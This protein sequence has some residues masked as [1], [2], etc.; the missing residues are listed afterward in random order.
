M[1]GF[2][3]ADPYQSPTFGQ[4]LSL[5]VDGGFNAVSINPSGRDVV[6]A[7]RTGLYVI[8]LDDPFS[9]PRWLQH[10]TSWQ[11]ADVQWSPHPAKPYWV[12]STSNQKAMV[13]NLARSSPNAI[14]HELHGHFRAITD[15]NFHPNHP[16]ILAT[17]SIDT[18]VHAWD[19]RS[20]QRPY[21]STRDLTAGASQ[22][23]WNFQDANILASS[24]SNSV[25]IWD[26]RKGCTPLHRLAA[27]G[28]SVNNIDFNRFTE[29]EIMSS[30]NNGT[31]KFWDYK[32]D[33]TDPQFTIQADFPIRRGRYLPF[34]EGCCIMPMVGGN[35]SVY[36][37]NN[38]WKKELIE[39]KKSK[40]QPIY[41]FKGHSNIVT[42]FLWRCRH[43]YDSYTD[44]RE[45]QLVTWSKDCNLRLWPVTSSTYEKVNFEP[46]KRLEKK[47]P[48]YEYVTF[49]N[50]PEKVK[51]TSINNYKVIPETFVTNSGFQ[52]VQQR[53]LNHLYW[54]SGVKMNQSSSPHD[55][56]SDS[57]LQSLGEE[58]SQV[59]HKFNK[60]V[61][62]K[63]SV[64]TGEL[65]LTLNGPWA[66][67]VTSEY[68]FLRVEIN[69]SKN[70]P[71]KG[72]P[73]TFKLEENTELTDERKNWL[74][75]QLGEISKIC[76]E[77]GKYCLE[78]C[79]RFLLGEHVD[80]EMLDSDDSDEHLLNLDIVDEVG[81]DY[82]SIRRSDDK[83]QLS[84][85]SASEDEDISG[86]NGS[87][88]EKK[89][90]M[91]DI[92]FD[93][94]PV[95]KGCGAVWTATGHLLCF[96]AGEPDRKSHYVLFGGNRTY[97]GNSLKGTSLVSNNA[98]QISEGLG[99]NTPI[100][101]PKRYVETLMATSQPP[102]DY[103]H[104]DNDSD[105]SESD[106][107]FANDWNDILK[108]DITL[109]TK[110]PI[111]HAQ[112]KNPISATH[113]E[114]GRTNDSKL[115]SKNLIIT[116]D[117]THLLQA[118]FELAL[119]YKLT[120]DTIEN[121]ARY[122]SGVAEKHGETEIAQ[123]WRMVSDLLISRDTNNFTNFVWD[124]H[125]LGGR[126]LVKEMIAYFEKKKNIQM[127]AMLACIL[128]EPVRRS[129]NGPLCGNYSRM[130]LKASVMCYGNS[131][132]TQLIHS[133]SHV[134]SELSE[135]PNT[136]TDITVH[137]V[138]SRHNIDSISIRSDDYFSAAHYTRNF[139]G[140]K[141]RSSSVFPPNDPNQAFPSITVEVLHDD[142]LDIV[143][144]KVPSLL[145]PASEPKFRSYRRQYAELMY[146]WG[147]P[148]HRVQVLKFNINEN[149]EQEILD[150]L[151]NTMDGNEDLYGGISYAWLQGC[152][153]THR[154][155]VYCG[156]KAVKRIFVCGN[157]QHI[158]HSSCASEWWKFD[159]E[160]P[161]GCGCICPS[162]FNIH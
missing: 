80:F 106:D 98:E 152:I 58:V 97:V 122:N 103:Y 38:S 21:Y 156:L 81:D 47:L 107:S 117:F 111:F 155:C 43:S 150:K 132:K 157:C 124:E 114:S 112:F 153:N 25:Y 46:G 35:N 113:S 53:A 1:G 161:S 87:T 73:P 149:T 86:L 89:E 4:S 41:V 23:K 85:L 92:A 76:S 136:T 18:Y 148:M 15:I 119:E 13:W 7:S 116:K 74:N 151:D 108:S 42:D 83:L 17:C 125:P 29:S 8:D 44:D 129:Y 130:P 137:R 36:L 57:K 75:S 158:L 24:H 128:V 26:V 104:T 144:E 63:I 68:V 77:A 141:S 160:C 22:V 145:D 64:S 5:R 84:D 126:L 33:P 146:Y 34:G 2:I 32:K 71:S 61:F 143:A 79:L 19:M 67:G 69:F 159:M 96:F 123:C 65:V 94:T 55:F 50:E 102:N 118:K 28:S 115:R 78:P 62:E 100:S 82:S 109:R 37:V 14:E 60:I 11:V 20:P 121:L 45:F 135:T 142:I 127:L 154:N 66:E 6:L 30:S 48:N 12:I 70:Y 72:N 99:A 51:S 54:V 95:P 110:M 39:E 59:G 88:M 91:T 3:G 27:D 140:F 52:N 101:R 133:Q 10:I 49:R 56:F 139:S 90:V 138:P 131:Y 134:S 31:V 162:M 147:L 9:P 120:G 105:T 40:L 93:S 16:E